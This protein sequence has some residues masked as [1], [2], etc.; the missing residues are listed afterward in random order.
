MPSTNFIEFIGSTPKTYDYY[1]S[2]YYN[3]ESPI[4]KYL[5]DVIDQRFTLTFSIYHENFHST[6][7][8]VIRI[9]DD[10]TSSYSNYR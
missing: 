5:P 4:L 1:N 7:R 10:F 8:S 2:D 3:S 6:W 9:T